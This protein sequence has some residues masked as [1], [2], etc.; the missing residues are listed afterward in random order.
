M[1]FLITI[2]IYIR[3]YY[4]VLN[5]YTSQKMKKLITETQINNAFTELKKL[6]DESNSEKIVEEVML[7]QKQEDPS[8]KLLL[9]N[10]GIVKQHFWSHSGWDFAGDGDKEYHSGTDNEIM[11]TD[12][13][14]REAVIFFDLPASEIIAIKEKIL[15]PA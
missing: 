7:A 4:G 14:L 12:D 13:E 10:E 15:S 11:T 9:T 2:D 3:K 1:Q 8:Y 5:Q 6:A